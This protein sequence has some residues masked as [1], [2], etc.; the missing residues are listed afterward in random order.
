MRHGYRLPDDAPLPSKAE[1]NAQLAAA[2]L[3]LE[4]E[5][6]EKSG[7]L[8]RMKDEADAE[9]A[10]DAKRQKIVDQIN[11]AKKKSPKKH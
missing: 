8:Q 11:A 10:A 2:L 7:R 4:Q 9:L 3:Q 1:G 6:F 5:A